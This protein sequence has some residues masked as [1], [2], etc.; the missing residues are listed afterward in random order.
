MKWERGH[1]SKNVED[2]RG[3]PAPRGGGA[4]KVGGGGAVVLVIIA[5][6][7]KLAGVDLPLPGDTATT[8]SQAGGTGVTT[9]GPG[10]NP[11]EDELV[12]FIHF[13]VDDIQGTFATV[14][15]AE[16]HTYRDAK[17]KIFTDAVATGC[18]RSSAA[19]GPFYCPPD[20][21]AYIDLSFYRELRQRFGAPGD[22]AQ[23][24]VLAHE[25]GHHCQQL[26]G[27]NDEVAR[28]TRRDRSRANELSVRLELQADCYAGVWA[29]ST[30][31]RQLLDAGDIEESLAAAAAIGDDRLQK[32]A[33]ADVN[34][35]TWTHG[36]SAQRVRWFKIG[37]ERGTLAACD[38]F[39]ALDL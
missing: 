5:I 14:F 26:L 4:L 35:E 10:T 38:T 37:L 3:Q 1:R 28:A 34:P 11:A 27:A 39:A 25:F 30:R 7:A 6:I 21:K 33:G 24:Y 17:L 13:A 8:P 31:Q 22:F 20:E 29:H 15:A 32:M 9:G 2:A 36:S 12:G 18:G 23:A 16:G 19:I